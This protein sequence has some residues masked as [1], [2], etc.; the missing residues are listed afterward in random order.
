MKRFA[1]CLVAIAAGTI[2]S[3]AVAQ[4]QLTPTQDNFESR[5]R[6]AEYRRKLSEQ[7]A[8]ANQRVVPTF[9]IPQPTYDPYVDRHSDRR[10]RRRRYGDGQYVFIPGHVQNLYGQLVYV[11]PHYEYVLR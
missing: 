8:R 6:D 2:F 9:V 11:P 10:F 1:I 4:A 7:H 5:R 3:S